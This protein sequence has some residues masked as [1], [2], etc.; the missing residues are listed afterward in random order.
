LGIFVTRYIV[1]IT[2]VL[3]SIVHL[4]SN[5]TSSTDQERAP[6]LGSSNTTA[7]HQQ[8][9]TPTVNEDTNKN[10]KEPGAF[11]DFFVKMKK[12]LPFIWPHHN[13][14]L[15]IYVLLCFLIMTLGF[16]VNLLAPR[17]IGKIVD[18]LRQGQFPWIPILVYIGLKF[19]QGGVCREKNFFVQKSNIANLPFLSNLVRS[20]P[21]SAKLA[22]DPHWTIYHA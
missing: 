5:N 22:L 15:Q 2:I 14:K 7:A 20:P 11:D 6:L 9:G 12:L 10:K 18:N 21:I 3:L 4:F 8:Y 17:Q 16:A 13:L 19:L 1:E